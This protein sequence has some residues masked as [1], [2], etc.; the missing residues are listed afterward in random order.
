M[1][2]RLPSSRLGISPLRAASYAPE[3]PMPRILASPPPS[4]AGLRP[5]RAVGW[6]ENRPRRADPPLR[7]QSP[8][9]RQALHHPSLEAEWFHQ[10]SRHAHTSAVVLHCTRSIAGIP[11]R[12][13]SE[14]AVEGCRCRSRP[15][16]DGGNYAPPAASIT[17]PT[18]SICHNSIGRARSQR[19]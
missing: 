11:P 5:D 17:P 16:L 10:F 2:T 1:S 19:L 14:D 13:R 4:A 3:R 18:T 7:R 9:G 6:F 8:Q 15:P 12:Q